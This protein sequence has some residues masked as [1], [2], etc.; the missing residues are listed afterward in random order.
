MPNRVGRWV[1]QATLLVTIS[2]FASPIRNAMATWWCTLGTWCP[3]EMRAGA[4][5]NARVDTH[6]RDAI[7]RAHSATH[8]LHYSLQKNLGRHAQQQG[9]KVDGDWLRFDFTNQTPVSDDELVEIEQDVKDRIAAQEPVVWDYVPLAEARE[10][11]AMMLFGE[12]YPDPVRLVS[13]GEFSRELCGGTHVEN[14]NEVSAFEIVSEE[15]V[16]TGTRRVVALTG[17]K[18]REHAKQTE[19]TLQATADVLQVAAGDVAPTVRTLTRTLRDLR[20]QLTSGTPPTANKATE[21]A[22]T[23]DLTTY[24]AIRAALRETA[25]LLNVAPLDVPER[26]TALLSEVQQL[27]QQVAELNAGGVL[28]ADA[29]IERSETVGDVCVIVCEAPGANAN[30]MRQ[31]IDQIRKKTDKAAVLLASTQSS[32][33][34]TVVAGLSREVIELGGNAGNWAKQTAAVMGGGGG[35]R[36]DMAQAGGK[37]PDKLPAALQEARRVID[38]V[39][40]GTQG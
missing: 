25:R 22:G 37:S 23:S 11:G 5:V 18:A 17:D 36:A 20:K 10:K 2:P 26:V 24:P 8:I 12:K 3:V 32:S 31:L 9:S 29:L 13:M 33:K 21:S 39:L 38:A 7:R 28:S 4:T 35:G 16:S 1:I 14:T 15:S 6:R 27:K 40:Q 34:V 30:L 19:S